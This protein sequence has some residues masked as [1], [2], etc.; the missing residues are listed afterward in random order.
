MWLVITTSLQIASLPLVILSTSTSG[1]DGY[2]LHYFLTLYCSRSSPDFPTPPFLAATVC[3]SFLLPY[4]HSDPCWSMVDCRI[5]HALPSHTT[6]GECDTEVGIVAAS[7]I[8]GP[9]AKVSHDDDCKFCLAVPQDT[10]CV[11]PGI[12]TG[13]P[14]LGE[15]RWAA[16]QGV[17]VRTIPIDRG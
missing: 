6:P 5:L 17:A 1:L 12:I 10:L 8:G 15:P 3:V 2:L 16:S 4:S 14:G 9:M 7:E 13:A 11:H